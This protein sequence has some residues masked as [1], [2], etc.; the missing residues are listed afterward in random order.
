MTKKEGAEAP[1]ELA[2]FFYYPA[3]WTNFDD[4]VRIVA[5][6]SNVALKVGVVIET[7]IH[8]LVIKSAPQRILDS[9]NTLEVLRFTNAI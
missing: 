9:W 5:D 4:E 7:W 1:S 6:L 2:G 3:T 8:P